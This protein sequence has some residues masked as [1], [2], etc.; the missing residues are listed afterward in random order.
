MSIYIELDRKMAR[1][2]EEASGYSVED[3]KKKCFCP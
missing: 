2:M 1:Q 3:R